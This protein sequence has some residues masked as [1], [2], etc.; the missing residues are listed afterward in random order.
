M[1]LEEYRGIMARYGYRVTEDRYLGSDY[2]CG[3][4]PGGDDDLVITSKNQVEQSD[5]TDLESYMLERIFTPT[6][7]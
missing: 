7:P 6:S 5:Q 1:K 2:L 4:G 3:C